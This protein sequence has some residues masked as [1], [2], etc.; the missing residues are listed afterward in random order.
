MEK[1]ELWDRD[2]RIEQFQKS[3][4]AV[5]SGSTRKQ[6]YPIGRTQARAMNRTCGY[7]TGWLTYI[8][9][10]IQSYE[11]ERGGNDGRENGSMERT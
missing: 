7:L 10:A 6:D 5:F 9:S 4:V 8:L 2:A 3:M 1:I 11:N